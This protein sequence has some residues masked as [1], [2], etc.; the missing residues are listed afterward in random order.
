MRAFLAALYYRLPFCLLPFREHDVMS[1][2]GDQGKQMIANARGLGVE[3]RVR[4]DS[5][6]AGA[7]VHRVG[8]RGRDVEGSGGG[9]VSWFSASGGCPPR[10]VWP[11]GACAWRWSAPR[12]LRLSIA[13][14]RAARGRIILAVRWMMDSVFIAPFFWFSSECFRA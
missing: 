13:A 2:R 11:G 9:F 14:A 10:L 5:G 6:I 8:G 1:V 3:R 7:V 4:G 12:E